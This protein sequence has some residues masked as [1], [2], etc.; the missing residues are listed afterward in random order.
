VDAAS[1]LFEVFIGGIS[2]LGTGAVIVLCEVRSEEL[3]QPSSLPLS[4]FLFLLVQ[5][6]VVHVENQ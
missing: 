3:E 4:L 1:Q 2:R 5:L 6:V